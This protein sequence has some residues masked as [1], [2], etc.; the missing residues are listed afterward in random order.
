M[1]AT[2]TQQT[3]NTL[4]RFSLRRSTRT[5]EHDLHL[6]NGNDYSLMKDC[7][8]NWTDAHAQLRKKFAEDNGTSH[9]NPI[10]PTYRSDGTL[11]DIYHVKDCTVEF[12]NGDNNGLVYLI[13]NNE[14][15]K[16]RDV[17]FEALQEVFT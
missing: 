16:K 3:V 7:L 15:Y 8:D 9:N 17:A 4:G 11:N 2:Q 12:F 1:E 10:I 6:F 13:I 14:D 5:K